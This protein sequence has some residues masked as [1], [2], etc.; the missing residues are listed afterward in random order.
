[1]QETIYMPSDFHI[2]NS[3]HQSTALNE[4]RNESETDLDLSKMPDNI[5][6]EID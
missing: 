5:Y 6:E 4:Y 1:M 2:P 3:N